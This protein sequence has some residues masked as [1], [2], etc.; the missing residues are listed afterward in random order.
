MFLINEALVDLSIPTAGLIGVMGYAVVFVGLILL[1]LVIT[2]VGKIM[3]SKTATEAKPVPATV[4][5]QPQLPE[6]AGSAGQLKLHDVSDKDA[7]LLMAI[8]AHK[9][10]KP[11][12]TLRFKS[13]KEVPSDEI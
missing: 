2:V 6:A 5:E 4:S 9:T 12:N 8:V 13:I 10:G 3:K 7:A 11:L 1:M